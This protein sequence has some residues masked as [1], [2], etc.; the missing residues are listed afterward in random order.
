MMA[1]Y[2]QNHHYQNILKCTW[3]HYG[4]TTYRSMKLQTLNWKP[5]LL[6]CKTEGGW[7]E[8]VLSLRKM[9]IFEIKLETLAQSMNLIY[10]SNQI[11]DLY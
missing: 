10:M 11:L 1:I 6:Y 4:A 8:G 9:K 2:V 7:A 5:K 3:S